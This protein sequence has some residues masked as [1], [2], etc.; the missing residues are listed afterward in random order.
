VTALT[1]YTPEDH[2]ADPDL[3]FRIVHPDDRGLL[4]DAVRA[5]DSRPLIIRWRHKD[6]GLLWTEQR[7]VPVYDEKGVIIAIEGIARDVTERKKAEDAHRELAHERDRLLNQLRLQFDRMPIGLV[8]VDADLTILD[9]NPAAKKIFGFTKEDVV[10]KD[11]RGLIIP[12]SELPILKEF[13]KDL[14]KGEKTMYAVNKNLTN[15]GRTI[16]CEWHDTPLFD[17]SGNLIGIMGMVQDITDRRRAEEALRDSERRFRDFLENMHLCTVMLD[18]KGN[19]I[20]CNDYLLNLTGWT[21]D[22]V[23]GRDW[24]D[25]FIPEDLRD[26]MKTYFSGLLAGVGSLH[27]EN[28]ILTRKGDQRHIV[29]DNTLLRNSGRNI[30]AT[31]SIGI[32]VTEHRKTEGQLRQAQKME[33]VG[34]LA[35]GIAHDFNNILSA[36]VGYAHLLKMRMPDDSPLLLPVEHILDSAERAATLT[37]SLLAFSRKQAINIRPVDLNEVI[38]KIEKLLVRIIGEDIEMWTKLA[39]GSLAA[40]ADA[41]QVEQVLMNLATNARDAMPRGG[42]LT[43]HSGRFLMDETF[44]EA[45]GYG[46]PGAYALIAV[47]DTGQGMDECTREKIFEPF[48]TTKETGRGTGLGLAIVYGIVKQ[49][50]GYI[51]VSSEP[52][53]GT[54]FRIYLPLATREKEAESRTGGGAEAIPRGT[55]TLLVAED[56]EALRELSSS[57]LREFGYTV[58]DAVDGEEA[59]RKFAERKDDIRLIILDMIMPKKNGKEAYDEIR[60]MKPSVRALFVSGYTADIIRDKGMLGGDVEILLKPISPAVLLKKVRELLDKEC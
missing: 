30:V 34:Q 35:G 57:V 44:I 11:I 7:N 20:F 38:N 42:V 58:L 18:R 12:A 17:E 24:F 56:D 3:G 16:I 21:R 32:D 54:T 52:G 23:V 46:E 39:E 19:V 47:S 9:W 6:G 60:E 59:V 5:R 2:Y 8:L 53:K 50:N 31:A 29:W 15:D 40:M 43:I 48:F 51:N 55:E 45:H 36:I 27:H 1:G 28:P 22:E 25:L 4:Q 37:H 33:A 13:L 10:G 14:K 41:G 26:E 49:H